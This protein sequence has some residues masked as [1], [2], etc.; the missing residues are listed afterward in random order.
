MAIQTA[1]CSKDKAIKDIAQAQERDY[2]WKE[3]ITPD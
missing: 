1:G 2:A 3:G